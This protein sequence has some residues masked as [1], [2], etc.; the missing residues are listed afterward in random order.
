MQTQRYKTRKG[1]EQLRPVITEAEYR[2]ALNNDM[3]FCLACG[4]EVPQCEPD[5]RC[6]TCESCGAPKVYGLEELLFMDLV[7][8]K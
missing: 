2:H 8:L 7:V 3:G 1:I 5:M 4:Q 6:G